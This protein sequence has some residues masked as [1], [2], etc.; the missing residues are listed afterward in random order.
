[1]KFHS[2]I[3]QLIISSFSILWIGG[4]TYD[5]A[6]YY[7][8]SCKTDFTGFPDIPG[9]NFTIV[10]VDPS[11]PDYQIK[12][13]YFF[14]EKKGILVTCDG[15]WLTENEGNSWKQVFNSSSFSA[16]DISFTDPFHGFIAVL[17]DYHYA[18]MKTNDGGHEWFEIAQPAKELIRQFSFIDSLSGFAIAYH[19]SDDSLKGEFVEKTKDGGMT[20]EKAP[21][22]NVSYPTSQFI[23]MLPSGLGY[24]SGETG[25]FYLTTDSGVT[26]TTINPGVYIDGVQFIDRNTGFASNYSNLFKTS[27]GGLTWQKISNN[28]TEWFHFFSTND[29]ITLQ[30]LAYDYRIEGGEGFSYGCNAFLTLSPLSTGWQEGPTS[31]AFYIFDVNFVNDH[32]G[33]GMTDYNG[34]RIVK[35]FR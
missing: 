7:S 8:E 17:L 15:I 29:G 18:I 19:Y 33:Y 14:D 9:W 26:W 35:L 20:W 31:I 13:I 11:I 10:P 30:S 23:K 6:K 12:Q 22:L 4:C 25:T 2:F 5:V 32:L 28:G 3:F 34:P 16:Y 21:A 1:M 24:I 27:D